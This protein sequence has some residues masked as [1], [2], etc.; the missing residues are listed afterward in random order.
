MNIANE[1]GNA[2]LYVAVVKGDTDT[3]KQLLDAGSNMNAV[4]EYGMKP[5]DYIR[6]FESWYSSD[7]FSE[8]VKYKIKGKHNCFVVEDYKIYIY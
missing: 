4:N 3:A 5:L 7:L 8:K 6:D 1:E 2:P